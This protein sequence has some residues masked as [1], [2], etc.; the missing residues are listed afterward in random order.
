MVENE[1]NSAL[2][3]IQKGLQQELR[4]LE[5]VGLHLT[6][7]EVRFMSLTGGLPQGVTASTVSSLKITAYD[8]TNGREISLKRKLV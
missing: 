8:A 5:S 4:R 7:C 2:A 6:E 1:L 3:N